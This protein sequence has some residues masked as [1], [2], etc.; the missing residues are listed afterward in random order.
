M[1]YITTTKDGK[2]TTEYYGETIKKYGGVEILRIKVIK[3]LF[4]L[5]VSFLSITSLYGDDEQ[6]IKNER[7]HLL[8]IFCLNN[9][10]C[11]SE[12]F[13]A[14]VKFSEIRTK[15]CENGQICTASLGDWLYELNKHNLN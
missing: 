9:G 5:F 13:G 7:A 6:Q 2:G 4:I 1:K 3:A 14:G 8:Q 11:P 10:V 15:M 12:N